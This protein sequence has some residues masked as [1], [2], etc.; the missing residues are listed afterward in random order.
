MYYKSIFL[1]LFASF[2][3]TKT[4]AFDN[5]VISFQAPISVFKYEMSQFKPLELNK[6]FDKKE[7]DV[8][9]T[10]PGYADLYSPAKSAIN[11]TII[12]FLP[13]PFCKMFKKGILQFK[14][15]VS[16][17]KQYLEVSFRF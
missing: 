2:F 10:I 1:L 3:P 9:R 4:L 5:N 6:T 8:L 16:I 17:K 14:A 15:K 11:N 7:D 12:F 13:E